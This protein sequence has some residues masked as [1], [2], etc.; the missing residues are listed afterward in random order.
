MCA[1]G[2]LT[3]VVAGEQSGGAG[4]GNDKSLSAVYRM[5]PRIH[6]TIALQ[7]HKRLSLVPARVLH[8]HTLFEGCRVCTQEQRPGAG[9]RAGEVDLKALGLD[10]SAAV[11]KGV[12][13]T[14][15]RCLH[16][17]NLFKAVKMF[18]DGV[19]PAR[20]V[21]PSCAHRKFKL[22]F[23]LEKASDYFKGRQ[24]WYSFARVRLAPPGSRV[25]LAREVAPGAGRHTAMG[26]LS[27]PGGPS[28]NGSG[29]SG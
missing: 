7:L 23:V 1:L 27:S 4:R 16:T 21:L 19:L 26:V 15:S 18:H 22:L 5:M 13:A 10:G 17:L 3:R 9:A 25:D 20:E 2:N 28:C 14:L 11:K 8:A 6:E 12:H 24:V 29:Y